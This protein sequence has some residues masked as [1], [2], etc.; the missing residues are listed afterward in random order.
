[1]EKENKYPEGHCWEG[2][3]PSQVNEGYK[4]ENN[5]QEKSLLE[6]PSKKQ[7][8]LDDEFKTLSKE[9]IISFNGSVLEPEEYSYHEDAVKEF[10]KKENNIDFYLELCNKLGKAKVWSLS[11]DE[12]CDKLEGL[13]R[14]IRYKL[15]GP[16]LI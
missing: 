5:N 2:L 10:I 14:E 15:A 12:V 3:T 8:S 6:T 13:M 16:D 4:K 1:M 11:T 9:R 7:N